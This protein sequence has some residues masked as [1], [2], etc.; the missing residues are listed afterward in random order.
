MAVDPAVVIAAVVLVL[1][2][3][4]LVIGLLICHF[5]CR[6]KTH[7]ALPLIDSE[8][9][10]SA[11][12]R[13]TGSDGSF[14]YT[15]IREMDKPKSPRKIQDVEPDEA[16]KKNKRQKISN[17]Q[18][19]VNKPVNEPTRKVS[20]SKIKKG[21]SGTI[22]K[23]PSKISKKTSKEVNG[24]QRVIIAKGPQRATSPPLSPPNSPGKGSPLSSPQSPQSSPESTN[25]TKSPKSPGAAS[26]MT[27]DSAPDP[28]P[29]SDKL[30]KQTKL[31]DDKTISK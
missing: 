6:P 22:G 13:G 4:I 25:S 21:P 20:I 29:I 10:R 14:P 12:P 16:D 1:I 9:Q 18:V 15:P 5:C 23:V 11:G 19:Q 7:G 31:V 3:V 26:N 27:S 28:T 2:I 8:G 24:G 30:E 17:E